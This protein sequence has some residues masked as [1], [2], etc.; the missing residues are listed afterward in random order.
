MAYISE[1]LH[2]DFEISRSLCNAGQLKVV[3]QVKAKVEVKVHVQ[4]EVNV[5]GKG[6]GTGTSA[7]PGTGKSIGQ[8]RGRV[9]GS[10]SAKGQG[11]GKG[12]GT[13]AFACMFPLICAFFPVYCI[14]VF[15]LFLLRFF[16]HRRIVHTM[17]HV[18]V[19]QAAVHL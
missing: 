18:G 13:G 12:E 2:T 5:R 14:K 4:V 19:A 9:Q 10:G 16:H 17:F 6:K 11:T 3:V 15:H 1:R 7:R 8:G